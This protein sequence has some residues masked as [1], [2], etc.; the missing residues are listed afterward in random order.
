[1]K[2]PWFTGLFLC[3]GVRFWNNDDSGAAPVRGLQGDTAK[4]KHYAYQTSGLAMSAAIMQLLG[5]STGG[6][7]KTEPGA[8][9]SLRG[10]NQTYGGGRASSVSEAYILTLE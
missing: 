4:A 6:G 7:E 9:P 1:M 8:D 3:P 5:R 10:E 2:S